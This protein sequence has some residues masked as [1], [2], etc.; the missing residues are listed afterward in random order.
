MDQIMSITWP[1]LGKPHVEKLALAS[2]VDAWR[3]TH[4]VGQEVSDEPRSLRNKVVIISVLTRFA[5]ST[6]S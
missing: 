4:L 3:T 5:G 2:D 6:R 1:S